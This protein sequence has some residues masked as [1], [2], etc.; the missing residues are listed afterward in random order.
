MVRIGGPANAR[1]SGRTSRHGPGP[2][3]AYRRLHRRSVTGCP[4]RLRPVVSGGDVVVNPGQDGGVDV[5]GGV[6]EA[7][8]AVD[9]L[10]MGL[11]GDGVGLDH[12]QGVVHRQGRLGAHPVPDPAQLD[13]VDAADSGH[14]A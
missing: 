1:A 14:V 11:V 8:N 10:M 12:A 5:D 2:L 9:Q 13:T 4:R 7:G 6:I 3:G